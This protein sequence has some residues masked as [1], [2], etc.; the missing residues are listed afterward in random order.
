MKII[1]VDF[2]T[3]YDTDL[4]FSCQTTE[5]YI[6]D[7]RFEIIGVGIKV[8]SGTTDWLSGT[9]KQLQQYL[10]ANYDWKNSALLAHNTL[11]DAA[12]LSWILDI[13]PKFLLDTLSMARA[14]HGTEV[15]GSLEAMVEHYGLG[16]KGTE[17]HSAKGKRRQD[18][19]AEE[20]SSY[21]D[22]CV[23]DVELTA[24]LFREL[25][26][27]FPRQELRVIDLTLSMFIDPVLELDIDRLRKHCGGIVAR[28]AKTVATLGVSK[29]ELMSNKQFAE[30][31]RD[32]GVTPPTKIS[33]QTGEE[34]YAFAKS[35]EAFMELLEHRNPLVRKLVEA[36]L[37]CKSVLEET[38][39]NTLIQTA[40]NNNGLFP[41]PIKYYAAHT[42][43]W[44]GQDKVNVQ[45]FPS[46][47]PDAKVLKACIRAPKGYIIVDADSKQIE[48]R[49]LA[50]LAGQDDLTKAFRNMEDVYVRMAAR[51]YNKPEHKVTKSER[52]VGKTTV[53][54]C[55][56]GMGAVRFKEQLRI[57]G[58]EISVLEARRIISI[59]R[60]A[61]P[62]IVR[63]WRQ[64]DAVL[65]GMI[66]KSQRDIGAVE[67][68]SV[69][70]KDKA[71]LLPNGMSIKYPRLKAEPG[72]YGNDY[73]YKNRNGWTKLYG[74]KVV[75]NLCQALARNIIAEQMLMV[76]KQE[77]VAMTVHDSVVCCVKRTEAEHTALPYI[78]E[79]MRH[80]PDWAE[81]L[82][83][84]CDIA[85][86]KNYGETVEIKI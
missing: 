86:G 32:Q 35:D 38:R 73:K 67:V 15:G 45:N 24:A 21:G 72:E 18:F 54:G 7:P 64:C 39:A 31:L 79:C 28:K 76:A 44:G 26:S 3:Y 17:V 57:L 78:A 51:I 48:A 58:V 41:V 12:I 66:S 85:I 25:V 23:N 16:R 42:G 13:R 4:G 9:H 8:G 43:R 81:G 69:S 52:F 46:R 65:E 29:E 70:V 34:T 74:G 14:L 47:G 33:L 77:K 6:R 82:P 56:Y 11:F 84:D 22:Y 83:L 68:V 36:R 37:A 55:G 59:Y 20:L 50:W 63:L 5:Q 62:Q 27:R 30:L 60:D 75:E 19:T 2:E 40:R 71:I 10:Q 49:V 61:N 53:L 1:T 80:V